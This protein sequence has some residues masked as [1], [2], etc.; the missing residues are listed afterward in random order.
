M[1]QS[2][3]RQMYHRYCDDLESGCR[4]R[5]YIQPF[6][7][8]EKM[9]TAKYKPPRMIQARHVTFN[10][11]Y[12][13][14]IKPL[15]EQITKVGRFKH[16]FGKGNYDEIAKR[17]TKLKRHYKYFTEL[18]HDSFDAHVTMELL[19]LTHTFYQSC[20]MHNK[21]LRHL[22]KKTYF[23][24]CISREG[25]RYKVKATRMSGDVDTSLGNSLINYAILK[26]LLH[27]LSISGDVIVNGDDSIIFTNE[28]IDNKKALAILRKMNMETKLSNSSCD[29]HKIEFCR[30]KY[31]IRDDGTPTMMMNPQRIT[32]MYGMTNSNVDYMQY[33]IE[34][35]TCNA[36]INSNTPYGIHWARAFNITIDKTKMPVFKVLDR[37]IIRLVE[38]ELSSPVSGTDITQSM[39]VAWHDLD[40]YITMIY[41]FIHFRIPK[42][43]FD[44]HI[45][46]DTKKL[47]VVKW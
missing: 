15:E 36:Y 34:V 8:I 42:I 24:N 43:N 32:E 38:R 4:V 31:V 1:V 46:H 35:A 13:K 2:T 37:S 7:K 20:Y 18:D 26:E 14:Y 33:L 47:V 5:S 22:S 11:E 29:I 10:I 17:I 45:N 27:Q 3:R 16:N 25:D 19:K 9:T 40:K 39:Y 44:I 23:N 28:P 41:K 21:E 6:T 30:T 12:G